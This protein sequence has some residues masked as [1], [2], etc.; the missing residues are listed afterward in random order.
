MLRNGAMRRRR[1]N[2]NARCDPGDSAPAAA[3]GPAFRQYRRTVEPVAYSALARDERR[4]R[5]ITIV[6]IAQTV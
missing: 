6:T 1:L 2:A 5:C 3:G 4:K